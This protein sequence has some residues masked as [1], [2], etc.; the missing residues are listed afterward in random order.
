MSLKRW[1]CH[2]LESILHIKRTAIPNRNGWFNDH[3]G[4][5]IDVQYQIDHILYMM[6][7]EVIPQRIIIGGSRND[8]EIGITISR[9][10]IKRS[11]QV[12]IFL[13]EISLDILILNRW[14]LTVDKIHLLRYHVHR[15]HRMMLCQQG[16]DTQS[17]V[18]GSG[19]GDLDF[20]IHID[21]FF[22]SPK[23]LFIFL[24]FKKMIHS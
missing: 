24:I 21:Y 15:C 23:I 12:Q 1:I 17:H 7:I 22:V 4:I 20:F 10:A 9:L 19:H 2:K 16:S 13:S 18:T 3:H 5:R 14:F 8:N 11:S 6:C